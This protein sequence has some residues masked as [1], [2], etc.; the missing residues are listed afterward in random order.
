MEHMPEAFIPV[1][2]LYIRMTINNHP[3]IAFVDSGAQTSILSE[4]CAKRCNVFRY[5]DRRYRA[6]AVG[7]GGSQKMVGRLVVVIAHCGVFDT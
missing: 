5:V 4:S 2:M 7:I 1:H 6:N 3:V